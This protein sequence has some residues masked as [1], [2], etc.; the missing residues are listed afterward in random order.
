MAMRNGVDLQAMYEDEC[1][2][3]AFRA[4]VGGTYKVEAESTRLRQ[5][6]QDAKDEARESEVSDD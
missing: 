6:E 1:E 5:A 3:R 2:R 4:R